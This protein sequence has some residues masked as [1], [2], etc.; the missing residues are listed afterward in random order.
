MEDKDPEAKAEDFLG[1]ADFG[2]AGG[3]KDFKKRQMSW[4]VKDLP[5]DEIPTFIKNTEPGKKTRRM[6]CAQMLK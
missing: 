5:K 1:Y 4:Y 2:D 3:G 6:S